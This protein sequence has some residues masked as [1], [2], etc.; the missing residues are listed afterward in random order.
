M[1][2]WT[3]SNWTNRVTYLNKINIFSKLVAYSTC[4]DLSLSFMIVLFHTEL[5]HLF[6]IDLFEK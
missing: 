4:V 6:T 2:N 3:I 5:G 1:M